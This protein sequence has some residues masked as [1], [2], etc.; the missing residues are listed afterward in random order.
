MNLRKI[1]YSLPASLRFTVRRLVYLPQDIWSG[2]NKKNDLVPPKGLIFTGAGDFISI[3]NKLVNSL[4]VHCQLQPEHA[5]LDI[6]CGIGRVAIPLTEYLNE[7]GSYDGFDV[8]DT[9]INWCKKR[10]TPRFPNF[11]FLYI[12]LKND[13]YRETGNDAAD[14]VFPYEDNSFD[15]IVLTS[16]FT[17]MLPEEVENYLGEIHRVLKKG[18]KCFVTF[19]ILNKHSKAFIS[20]NENFNFPYHKGHYSLMDEKV[21]GANVAFEEDYLIELF[22]QKKLNVKNK[23]YGFWA[24]R[25]KE[26]C[27]DFQDVIILE[28]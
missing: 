18:G 7:N 11:N 27:E 20:T 9:G 23:L 19:F 22:S 8:I 1:Y 14:F 2:M 3:G 12:P 6:G 4:K 16:V 13:L 24:N 26:N 28:K 5:V 25:K 21:K 15:C 10:V 17:H